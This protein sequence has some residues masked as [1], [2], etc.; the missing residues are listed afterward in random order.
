METQIIDMTAAEAVTE[1]VEIMEGQQKLLPEEQQAE[2]AEQLH[3]DIAEAA[4]QEETV[5]GLSEDM[6]P[7]AL[8]DK[9]IQ[10]TVEAVLFAAGYP[11]SY[12][13]LT[14]ILGIERKR[15]K[16]LLAD[17]AVQ[18]EDRGIQLLILDEACQLCSKERYAPYV[19][20]ALGIKQGGNLSASSLEVLAIVAYHQPVTKAYI[21]QVRG[22]DC[23]YA[24]TS[25]LG[26]NLIERAGRLDV[27]GRPTLYTTTKDFLRCF[28]ITSLTELPK[29]DLFQA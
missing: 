8:S 14:E 3:L 15:L 29:I 5:E 10:K 7:A 22:V 9:E 24:L 26:K 13:K 17:L 4:A 27:P 23:T 20:A 19:R 12:D 11:V 1:A 25:L 16:A 28:G 21:E 6:V 2:S 18:Y